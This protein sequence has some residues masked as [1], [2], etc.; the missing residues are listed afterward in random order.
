MIATLSPDFVRY[1]AMP[2][3]RAM[4]EHVVSSALDKT[5]H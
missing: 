1:C 5:L 3:E 2:D 4:M